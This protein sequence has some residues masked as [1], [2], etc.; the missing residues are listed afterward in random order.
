MIFIKM[1]LQRVF[2]TLI[3]CRNLSSQA[4][5]LLKNPEKLELKLQIPEPEFDIEFICNPANRD[6]IANNIKCRKG[7][8]NIDKVLELAQNQK[9]SKE[10]M[11]E[12]G[13]IPNMTDPH[14]FAYGNEPKV[15]KSCKT[16][17]NFEFTPESF[18]QLAKN[19]N[20]LRIDELGPVAGQKSYILL[21]DLAQMEEALVQY[22]IRKLMKC[23]FKLVSVPDILPR[24]IIERCGMVLDGERNLVYSLENHYGDDLCL[25]GTAEMSLAMKLM[26][27]QFNYDDLPIKLAAVSRCFRAEISNSTEEQ[28]IYRVHQFTKVEM[29]ACSNEEKSSE[30][31]DELINIQ[32]NLLNDLGLYYQVLDMPSHELGAPAARKLDIE[33]WLPGRKTFGE[34]SSCSNCTD[35]QSR[36]LNIKYKTINGELKH[37]HTLNGTACAIPRM[38]IAI[39]E[40]FQTKEGFI[41]VPDKLLPFMNGKTMIKKQN[42]ADM[43]NYKLKSHN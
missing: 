35:F 23:D 36:R 16:L 34:L 10:L 15:L 17:P 1:K 4:K 13:K 21:G 2:R 26:N 3:N 7:V 18:S 32:E 5:E 8:G 9:M 11:K 19:L 27:S 20:L 14:V 30:I 25:S 40:T 24:E 42:V 43:R 33:G 12:L 28:G 41:R 31:L 29:F 6:L 22:T 38:L 39:L 37:V